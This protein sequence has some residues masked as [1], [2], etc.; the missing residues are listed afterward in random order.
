MDCFKAALQ[1]EI[2]I[3]DCLG[4]ATAP[5]Q[6]YCTAKVL[7]DSLPLQRSLVINLGATNTTP[8]K[9]FNSLKLLK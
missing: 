8:F 7:I 6:S 3:T 2:S 5:G 4:F 1:L 9:Q